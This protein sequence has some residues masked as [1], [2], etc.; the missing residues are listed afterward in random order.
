[1]D[2]VRFCEA[3]LNHQQIK[4]IYLEG[5]LSHWRIKLD[6]NACVGE[7]TTVRTSDKISIYLVLNPSH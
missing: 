6:V 2:P 4:L 7:T 1:M 3:H 5:N